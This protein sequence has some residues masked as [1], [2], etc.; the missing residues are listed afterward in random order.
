MSTGDIF[1]QEFVLGEQSDEK[2]WCGGP[3]ST[4]LSISP[5]SKALLHKWLKKVAKLVAQEK[6]PTSEKPGVKTK[7]IDWTRANFQHRVLGMFYW[8]CA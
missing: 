2:T 6:S 3:G 5:R 7:K 8:M 4:H 1:R